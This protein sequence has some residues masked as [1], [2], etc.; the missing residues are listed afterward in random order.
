MIQ[1]KRT[2]MKAMAQASHILPYIAHKIQF[3]KQQMNDKNK[4]KICCHSTNTQQSTSKPLI[5]LL[6]LVVL[7]FFCCCYFPLDFSMI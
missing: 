6:L 1:K 4:E 3:E 2:E 5:Y 7:L